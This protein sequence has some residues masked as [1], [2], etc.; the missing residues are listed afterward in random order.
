MEEKRTSV[1]ENGLIWFGAAVS[2]AEI[3]TGTAFAPLGFTKGLLAILI[4]HVIGCAMLFF[5]GLI[6]GRVRKSAM[7]TAKM[8]FGRKGALLFSVL[9]IIQL[10]GWTAI[11]IYDG[12][13]AVNGI[14]DAGNW[15]WCIVIGVLIVLWIMIGIKNLGKVNTVAM[16]G[17]LRVACYIGLG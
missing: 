7:E 3:V 1:F 13:L 8:S 14:F 10:V 9:N 2:I 12:A 17:C 6:G 16:A 5:A 11:M 15:V 4:G